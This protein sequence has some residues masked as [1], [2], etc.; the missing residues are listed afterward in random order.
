MIYT[1]Q[2]LEVVNTFFR[3]HVQGDNFHPLQPAVSF[4][5]TC[6]TVFK[7]GAILKLRNGIRGIA[8]MGVD[9]KL[10][11]QWASEIQTSLDFLYATD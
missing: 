4:N 5:F 1:N 10:L 11:V 7:L 8:K 9:Q 3:E 6:T 2:N